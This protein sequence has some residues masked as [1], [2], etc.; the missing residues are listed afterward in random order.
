MTVFNKDKRAGAC[1]KNAF[2]WM[3]DPLST[4]VCYGRFVPN[5]EG[6]AG[7]VDQIWRKY[8][9]ERGVQMAGINL[10][11]RPSVDGYNRETV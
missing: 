4:R 7:Y 9:A 3:Y 11:T 5:E 8:R 1:F 6:I 10:K 2:F